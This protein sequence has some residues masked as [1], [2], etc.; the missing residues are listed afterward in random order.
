MNVSFNVTPIVS[1]NPSGAVAIC[2]GDNV[3]L[4]ASGA[5]SYTWNNGQSGSSMVGQSGSYIATG[6]PMAVLVR[7]TLFWLLPLLNP[8]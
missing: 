6:L 5:N 4:T 1:V 2:S 7:Q 8:L 3:T